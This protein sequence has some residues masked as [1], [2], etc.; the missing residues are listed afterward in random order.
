MRQV[1]VSS[2]FTS[3]TI[4]SSTHF[5]DI[6]SSDKVDQ[7]IQTE[8]IETEDQ[9]VQVGSLAKQ[10]GVYVKFS[11]LLVGISIL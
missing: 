1:I 7:Q 5:I 2:N 3:Y 10:Q 9:H 8:I 11:F 4:D 6:A